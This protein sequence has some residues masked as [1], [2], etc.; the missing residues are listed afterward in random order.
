MAAMAV[1][2]PVFQI[3]LRQ[4]TS[5]DDYAHKY[6]NFRLPSQ[7]PCFALPLWPDKEIYLPG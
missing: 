7:Q 1:S 4:L 5:K 6:L 2:Y 3:I